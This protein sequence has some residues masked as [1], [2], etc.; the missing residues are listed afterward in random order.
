[1]KRQ[2]VSA[3]SRKK[4][5]TEPSQ[6]QSIARF[7]T[8]STSHARH[9]HSSPNPSSQPLS[10]TLSSP[11]AP[12]AKNLTQ[13]VLS[14]G[15]ACVGLSTCRECGLPNN[16][17]AL[18]TRYHA[19]I[20]G[21]VDY[22]GYTSDT[23]VHSDMS[24]N[25]SIILI[26]YATAS[27]TQRKKFMQI[28]AVMNAELGAIE[29][30]DDS[31]YN[32]DELVPLKLFIFVVKAKVVE[33]LDPNEP[34]GIAQSENKALEALPPQQSPLQEAKGAQSPSVTTVAL[35]RLHPTFTSSCRIKPQQM[36]GDKD[37]VRSHE[38]TSSEVSGTLPAIVAGTA[39]I[40][41][42]R[43]SRRLRQTSLIEMFERVLSRQLVQQ[44][45]QQNA[46]IPPVTQSQTISGETEE[47]NAAAGV[48]AG[49]LEES[50]AEHAQGHWSLAERIEGGH[51]GPGLRLWMTR[52]VVKSTGR[53][54]FEE[55]MLR[56]RLR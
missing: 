16:D 2:S 8:P 5:K 29:I 52:S 27:P 36:Q 39:P 23:L 54:V 33:P 24:T 41:L 34:P 48:G 56:E 37:S 30:D 14:L 3:Q 35:P 15:Q 18:H 12:R 49:T 10:A 22:K 9:L 28:V 7:F 11:T 4:A 6:T 13:T 25:A 31:N 46:N 38:G 20:M 1:M 45:Q 55:L 51:V 21:G 50:G 32:S 42:Q 53:A 19:S 26:T 43:E 17:P 47:G 40:A 44:Q